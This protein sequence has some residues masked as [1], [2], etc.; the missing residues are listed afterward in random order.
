MGERS[1]V[2]IP[3]A[4]CY[5]LY[6]KKK[7]CYITWHILMLRSTS[8]TSFSTVHDKDQGGCTEIQYG[9]RDME[10]P[11]NLGYGCIVDA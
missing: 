7:A 3:L 2:Q 5:R 6:S 11:K 4:P 1:G 9:N 10:T 8:M